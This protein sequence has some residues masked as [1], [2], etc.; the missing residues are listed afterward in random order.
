M[1]AADSIGRSLIGLG[2]VVNLTEHFT[3]D[4]FLVSAEAARRGI[5]NTPSTE[6]LLNLSNT[7]KHMEVVRALLGDRPIVVQSGFRSKALND[8][9]PGSSKTSDHMLGLA[10]DFICPAFGSVRQVFDAIRKSG[11]E[12]DQL[13]VE[14]GSWV[15]IGFGERHRN[16]CLAYNGRGY[17]EVV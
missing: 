11:I 17:R 15:H 6:A 9:L 8:A 7:A 14:F 4:E 10:V 2:V 12:F 1:V 16:Q 13:I 3:L 5:D